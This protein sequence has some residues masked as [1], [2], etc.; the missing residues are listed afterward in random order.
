MSVQER[1]FDQRLSTLKSVDIDHCLGKG[2]RSFLWQV[3]ADAA[4][5]VAVLIFA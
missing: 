1:E 5:D 4:G 3:V 2:L